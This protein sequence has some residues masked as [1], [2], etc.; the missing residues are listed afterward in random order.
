MSAVPDK[1]IVTIRYGGYHYI[2][3]TGGIVSDEEARMYRDYLQKQ[4]TNQY[5]S[6]QGRSKG[7]KP[8]VYV[9]KRVE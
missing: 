1:Y 4:L 6:K 9:W 2:R 7:A 3:P 5:N 8:F